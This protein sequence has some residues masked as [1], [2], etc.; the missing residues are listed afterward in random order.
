MGLLYVSAHTKAPVPNTNSTL[1]WLRLSA[2]PCFYLNFAVPLLLCSARLITGCAAAS[3]C[4][5]SRK[6]RRTFTIDPHSLPGPKTQMFLRQL[7][8]SLAVLRDAGIIHCDL[9][10]E[11]ILLMNPQVCVCVG[12]VVWGGVGVIVGVGARE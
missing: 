7:L 9:K 4:P 12:G 2:V 3:S 1:T 8:D 11:N 10:P 6:H 5:A